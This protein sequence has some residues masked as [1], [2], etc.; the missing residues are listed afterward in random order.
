MS[1]LSSLS[2]TFKKEFLNPLELIVIA[3]I[4]CIY[5]SVTV[6]LLN[7]ALSTSTIFGSF[8]LSYKI[9]LLSG[10]ILGA[11]SALGVLDVCMLTLTSVL[12]GTNMVV[13]FKNLKK[14]K[15]TEGKL[16]VSAGGGAVIG[17][18]V[19]GCTSCGFSVFALLGLT[20]AV[21]LFPYEGTVI[22]LLII[23][24]LVLSLIYS[25]KTLQREIYCKI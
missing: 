8:P 13:V 14:L 9:N 17:I 23:L 5:F 24:L 1:T 11:S 12:V 2:A 22:G 20:G 25:L 19:A 16:V 18:F 21:T 4:S 3:V 15:Q 7:P 10:L 6:L